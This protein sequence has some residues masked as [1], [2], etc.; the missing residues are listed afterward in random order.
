MTGRER[1]LRTLAFQGTD[2]IPMDMWVLPAARLHHGKAFEDLCRKNA[3]KLDIAAFV[4]PIDHGLTPEYYQVGKFTDPWGSIWSNLQEGVIGEV[5]EPVL[6]DYDRLAGYKAPT[7]R[8]LREWAAEKE[9][10]AGRIA[11]ARAQGK[12][13]L[14]GWISIFERLQ[15]LRGTEDLYC[16]IALEEDGMF[17]MMD[18]VMDFMR[19]YLDA[20]LEMDID[21]IPFGDDWGS[22]RSL[23]ISPNAWVKLF[24]PLYQELF[25]R[26]HAAGKKVFFHSDGYIWDL[27]PHFI[28]MGVDAVNSQLW[29]MGVKKVAE[30]FAGKITF[31]GEISRQDILPQG[32]PEEVKAAAK[33]MIRALHVNGGGL[34]GQSEI[35]KDV[36]LANVEAFFEAWNEENT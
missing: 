8:F 29:C 22:Q 5:K 30:Q 9:A 17:A 23:L 14:G 21:G 16:D 32:S 34:I 7:E 31:W 15:F 27:Y 25:D 3:D 36:P 35:N 4:G 1:V 19:V 33:A 26:I 28:D 10:L 12:F 6:A 13:I 11:E 24:K 20:W 2:R 18:L